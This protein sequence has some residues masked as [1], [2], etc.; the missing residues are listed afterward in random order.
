MKFIYVILLFKECILKNQETKLIQHLGIV[1]GVCNEV[2]LADHI[3]SCIPIGNRKVSVGHCVQA[4]ILNALG[5]AGRALYLT[6]RFF[7][8][9]PIET[10]ITPGI[11]ANE[12]HDTSLGNA[13]D[14]IYEYG[15]TELFF[16]TASKILN[17]F[18]IKTR[19]AHLDSTT[20]SLYGKYN[21]END[22]V[23]ED[24]IRITKGYSK[25]N[26][27]DLNQVVVQLICSNKTSIPLWLEALSGNTS[28]KKSFRETVKLFQNQFKKD[29][30]PYMVMDSAFY[31]E[32]NLHECKDIKWVTRVPE[33]IKEVK[34]LYKTI[35]IEEMI[36]IDENYSYLPVKSN[37]A[38]I[39]QRWL[40]VYSEK[41][42]NRE[43]KTFKKNLSKIRARNKIDLK[44]LCNQAFA[45]KADA[46]E[47]AKKFSKK[48]RYQYLSYKIVEKNRYK[49]K[50]R[51]DKNSIPEK[52][53]WF[54]NGELC[55]D[56]EAINITEKNKGMFII[57]TNDMDD[58]KLSNH[59]LFLN[60]KDQ[61]ITVERGFR[62]LKDPYFYAESLYLKKPE[63]IM[64]LIMVMTL[65]LLIYSLAELKVRESLKK[66]DIYIWDQKNRL[67]Q[68]PTI[69]WI[70]MIF[71]DVLLLYNTPDLVQPMNIREEH[72][73]VLKSLGPDYEKMY[74]L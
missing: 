29:E 70:C 74:F 47:A 41:A 17:D 45:C 4:M 55:D 15:I 27:P 3:N 60:Y 19:F 6:K 50:G 72:L 14:A 22:D 67:T 37:Y 20:F 73:R 5:F 68:T 56:E 12:L 28:D 8:S 62:F 21:S 69:R 23:P 38:N 33:T 63:R 52:V 24:I 13:L 2:K 58:E 40:V 10:L 46:D 30:M 65:S 32:K 7:I 51:P 59:D 48:I 49:G 1:A 35:N 54:I 44:H 39:Q 43:I 42:C 9:R 16:Q 31:S 11:N 64:A 25:D 36:K 66:N 34:A 53:E 18:G 61:G 71:E 26:A 57:S